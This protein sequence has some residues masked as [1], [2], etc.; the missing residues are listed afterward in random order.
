MN[1][2]MELTGAEPRKILTTIIQQKI[3]AI[4]S[5]QSRSKWHVAKVLV[6]DIGATWLAVEVVSN[7]NR[8]PINVQQD[9]PVG[10]AIKYGYGKFIFESKVVGLE[11]SQNDTCAGIIS[12]AAPDHIEMVQRRSYFRVNVPKTMRVNVV[13]WHRRDTDSVAQ[14]CPE[15]YFQGNLVDISAG[16]LQATTGSTNKAE[17]RKGQYVC[18]RFTPMPY[19]TPIM[20]DAQ[21]RNILP[22]ADNQKLCMGMQIVGLETSPQGRQMLSRIVEIV[23]R[24]YQMNRCDVKQNDFCQP[25]ISEKA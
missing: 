10:V 19:E 7:K 25:G 15:K 3:P 8:R 17:F 14:E 18:M 1:E 11:P 13:L 24:Y 4:L 9:Q 20:F 21:I 16:G 6:T 22:T 12:L 5:Y 23:E 2:V